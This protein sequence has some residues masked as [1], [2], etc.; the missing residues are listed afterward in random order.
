MNEK[1][2]SNSSEFNRIIEKINQ[3]EIVSYFL[4]FSKISCLNLIL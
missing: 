1:E 3:P 2:F 4:F